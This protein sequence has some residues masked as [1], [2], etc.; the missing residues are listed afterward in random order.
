MAPVLEGRLRFV[1]DVVSGLC[2]YFVPL[3]NV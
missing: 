1:V 2:Y 3:S